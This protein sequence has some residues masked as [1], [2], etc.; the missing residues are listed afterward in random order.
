MQLDN[1]PVGAAAVTGT[2]SGR[3][4]HAAGVFG[5]R[6]AAFAAT[7]GGGCA[8]VNLDRVD[9][10]PPIY[11]GT[12]AGTVSFTAVDGSVV[13]CTQAVILLGSDR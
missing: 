1:A 4:V 6:S 12:I 8:R 10:I 5:N 9:E 7:T 13:T 2:V 3:L 11:L